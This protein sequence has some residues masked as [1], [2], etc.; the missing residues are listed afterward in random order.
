MDDASEEAP[1]KRRPGRPPGASQ[2]PSREQPSRT[3]RSADLPATDQAAVE[4]G[5]SWQDW[6]REAIRDALKRHKRRLKAQKSP[7]SGAVTQ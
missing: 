3:L 2:K 4:R 1:E 7:P 6:M 5:M